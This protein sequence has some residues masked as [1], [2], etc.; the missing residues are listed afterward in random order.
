MNKK[1]DIKTDVKSL[2]LCALFSALIAVG[3]FIKIPFPGVPFTLQVMFVL[4]A[5]LL[6]GP[7]K[8]LIAVFV[9]IIIGLG[10]LPVFSGGGGIA[11]I[12]KPSFGYIIGFLPAVYITGKIREKKKEPRLFLSAL[13]GTLLIYGIGLPYYYLIMNYYLDTPLGVSA[14]MVSGFFIFL[15]GDLIKIFLSVIL[16]KRM[17]P[18]LNGEIL[19]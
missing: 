17:I 3:A 7:Q 16:A 8:G 9:Y 4:L 5:G 2:S 18:V 15:P 13:I 11:Y 1:I 14:L 10:G 6:L 12:F 19:N